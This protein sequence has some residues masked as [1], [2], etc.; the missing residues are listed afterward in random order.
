MQLQRIW[1]KRL[2]SH[3]LFFTAPH[4]QPTPHIHA[5]TPGSRPHIHLQLL[6][7]IHDFGCCF[8]RGHH[9]CRL[10]VCQSVSFFAFCLFK[11][12]KQSTLQNG[13][14]VYV[15]IR[16]GRDPSV[17]ISGRGGVENAFVRLLHAFL[18]LILRSAGEQS[19]NNK[20]F[21]SLAVGFQLIASETHV[22]ERRKMGNGKPPASKLQ[23]KILIIHDTSRSERKVS[24]R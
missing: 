11:K 7:L 8:A 21:T 12:R 3:C 4:S 2:L 9:K 6:T 14:H 1:P 16:R 5:H 20:R 22:G 18:T 10:N 13:V 23:M 19:R 24:T 15:C 17:W